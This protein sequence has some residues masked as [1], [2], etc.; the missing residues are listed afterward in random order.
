MNFK[1]WWHCLSN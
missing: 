1:L